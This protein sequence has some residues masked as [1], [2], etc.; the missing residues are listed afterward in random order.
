MTNYLF[1]SLKVTS[2]NVRGIRDNTKRKAVFIFCRQQESDVVFLQETHS[3]AND[4]KIWKSQWGD[5]SLFSHASSQSA[6]VAVL[7]NKFKG[8]ILET[9]ISKD[10]RWIIVICKLDNTMFCLCNLYGHN[11]TVLSK[12]MFTQLSL[13]IKELQIK[14]NDPLLILGGDYNDAPDDNLDRIPPRLSH[15]TRF[16]S[17]AFFSNQ[18]S[19]I[20]AWRFLNPISKEYT[21]SNS[22]RTLRSRIDVWYTSPQCLQFI[23]EVFHGYAPLTDHKLISITLNG[24]NQPQKKIRGYWKFNNNLLNDSAFCESILNLTM[25][26]FN[27]ELSNPVQRWEYFKYQVRGLAITRSKEIKKQKLQ[28]EI[29]L[30]EDL[31]GLLVKPS[32]TDEEEI[33]LKHVQDE[34]DRIYI[35]L[36]KGAFVRSRTK[37]LEEGERNTSYFF[38]LEKRNYKKNNITALKINNQTSSDLKEITNY[39]YTFYR[40]IYKSNDVVYDCEQ[41]IPIIKNKIPQINEQFKHDCDKP[42]TKMEMADALKSMNKGKSPGCDGL[43][44]EFY[45]HFWNL[46]ENNL[47]EMFC[48][49]IDE[50][51]MSTTMKQ[52]SI[53]L[54]PK[55]G[56]DP[57]FIENWR[58]ITLLN[59]DYKILAQIYARRLKKGLNSIINET[60]TGFMAG[61]H[62]SSNVRLILDL[63]DYSEFI[64]TNSLIMF[65]DF[66]K[67]FDTVEHHFIFKTLECFGFGSNFIQAVTMLYKNINSSVMLYPNT[68]PRFEVQRSVRQGCVLAP[69]LFL[70]SVEMLSLYILNSSTIEGIRIFQRDLRITQLA[71][72]TVLF[73]K[74]VKQVSKAISLV[75]DFSRASGLKLNKTKCEILCL[76]NTDVPSICNIDIKKSVKYLGIH[77]CRNSVERQQQNFGPKIKKTQQILNMWLQRDLSIYGRVLLSKAEGISRLVYPA[78]SLFVKDSTST[79][80]NKLLTNFIWKNKHHHLKRNVITG[81]RGEGGIEMLDFFDLNNTFKVKWLQECIK[82][83]KSL[84]Y[85]IPNNIFQNF[86]G[87]EFLLNCNFCVSKLPIKLSNFYKQ[88]LSAWKL[89]YSH[90]F[91]PH[92]CIIWNNCCILKKNHSIISTSWINKSIIYVK[93]LV[94]NNGDILKYETF[95]TQFQFPIRFK[96]FKAVT[97]CLPAGLLHLMKG[98]QVVPNP[99]ISKEL[100]IDGINLLDKKCTNKIIRKT[101]QRTKLTKPKCKS[102]WNSQ[103][104][105]ID[106]KKTWTSPFNYCISNKIRETHFKI[107]HRYYPT[108]EIISKFTDV[109]PNC[110]FCSTTTEN[111]IHLFFSCSHTNKLWS[112]TQVYLSQKLSSPITINSKQVITYF[113]HNN[114]KISKTANLFILFGKHLIHKAKFSGSKPLFKMLLY[115]INC[116]MDSL[117]H[118][119]NKKAIEI[120]NILEVF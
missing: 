118:L 115:D 111:I 114:E 83:P 95:L 40:D 53:C 15:S 59:V 96:E 41:Y 76:Y 17:T 67:A 38:S 110:T 54:I 108:N 4:V 85:F 62:I 91:S 11:N 30:M 14:Y 6:G 61:R 82:K 31:N 26:A 52:G 106:W 87:L 1:N 100:F 7:F 112:E 13:K 63:I 74:D 119:S 51:E 71:D 104:Y 89:C 117:K 60:Q 23:T 32:L 72:D 55:P 92:K 45:I 24:T 116:Y 77:I 20:D 81:L 25:N 93:D 46:I 2:L 97:Q 39:I 90:N 21:W 9:T 28:K 75:E 29:K 16:K 109:N 107:L 68:T 19:V 8:D 66:Y 5:Y 86:G 27:S 10:G 35:E 101:L 3:V 42:I 47:F 64:E 34:I 98:H 12:N 103:F 36:A 78:L 37:W 56:K 120:Y 79:E 22:H 73:L 94:D 58:P 65:L 18:L 105:F 113:N 70:L 69:F 48:Q 43:T 88:A 44:L 80:I 49:C 57:L 99:V 50:V 33:K 84:W 102:K